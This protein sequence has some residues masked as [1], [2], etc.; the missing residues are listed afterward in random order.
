VAGAAQDILAQSALLARRREAHALATVVWRHR[1]TS[2]KAGSKGLVTADGR[3]Q[4]W[5]GGACAQPSVVREAL[6][7]LSEGTPRLLC[8]GSAEHFPGPTEGRV[9]EPITCS[10]E[11]AMEVFIE[12]CLPKPQVVVIGQAPVAATLVALAGAVGFDVA[13]V[14]GQPGTDGGQSG[15]DGGPP[16]TDGG[17]PGIDGGQGET[18]DR[19]AVAERGQMDLAAE[20][21]RHAVGSGSFVVVATMGR[22]DEDALAAALATKAPYVALVASRKRAAAV[23]DH[24]RRQGV[25][26]EKLQAVHAP[27]GLDLGP[28]AHEEIAV[29]ILAEIVQSKACGVGAVRVEAPRRAEA[30][31]PVCGMV[32]GVTG[33][34]HTA[35]HAGQTYYFCC[36]GCR[37]YFRSDPEAALAASGEHSHGG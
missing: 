7:A 5:V 32:V 24:L 23:L 19:E 12:P 9:I 8:L 21:A 26:E 37:E 1:P 13:E 11:G 17:K 33:A 25:A 36:A 27:A 16:G 14:G 6:R 35:E 20:L 31:D 18:G 4:G 29:A 28:I 3:L 22:F 2:G 10:S 15:I 34:H 30:V